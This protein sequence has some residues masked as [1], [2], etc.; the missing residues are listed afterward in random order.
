MSV[1]LVQYKRLSFFCICRLWPCKSG[2]TCC[3]YSEFTWECK[4]EKRVSVKNVTFGT[5]IVQRSRFWS[6]HETFLPKYQS[7]PSS[8]SVLWDRNAVHL[9]MSRGK[10]VGF[11]NVKCLS[12]LNAVTVFLCACNVYSAIIW[13]GNIQGCCQVLSPTRKETS[14]SDRRFWVSYILFVNIIG[15]ILVLFVYIIRLASNEIFSPSNKIHREVGRAKVLSA[16]P[17]ESFFFI[18]ICFGKIKLRRLFH[19]DL[20]WAFM[21]L[22]HMEVAWHTCRCRSAYFRF[23]GQKDVVF[24]LKQIKS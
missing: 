5:V 19:I 1:Q 23:V 20:R 8:I 10:F 17:Y 24:K 18:S 13:Q 21:I 2:E 22:P 12:L 14:Y 16:P 9:R 7:F 11:S 15:R 3:R 6:L 4:I